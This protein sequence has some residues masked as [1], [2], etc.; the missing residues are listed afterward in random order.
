[1]QILKYEV[2]P[3]IRVRNSQRDFGV[4]TQMCFLSKKFA[5]ILGYTITDQHPHTYIQAFKNSVRFS[6]KIPVVLKYIF[7]KV[8]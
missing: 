6:F 3:E 5:L 1:M 8:Y 7:F 4:C 2:R